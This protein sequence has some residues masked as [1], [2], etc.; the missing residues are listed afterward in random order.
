MNHP[1]Y[2]RVPPAHRALVLPSSGL[3]PIP[4]ALDTD[5]SGDFMLGFT[6]TWFPPS[7]HPP[8]AQAST[9][10]LPHLLVLSPTQVYILEGSTLIL[11]PGQGMI[12]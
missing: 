8:G 12:Q 9:Q 11:T 7:E 6:S 1:S 4:W 5:T 10:H 2:P 3:E